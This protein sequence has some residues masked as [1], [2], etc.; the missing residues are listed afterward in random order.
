MYEYELEA[1]LEAELENELEWEGEYEGEWESELEAELEAEYEGEEFLSRLVGLARRGAQSP[2]LRRAGAVAARAARTLRPLGSRLRPA[3]RQTGLD[4]ARAGLGRLGSIGG[5]IGGAPGTPGSQFGSRVGGALGGLL[6]SFLP[7]SEF[8]GEWEFEGE[9]NPLRRVYPDALMEH[10]AH[11]ATETESEEEA[12]AFIGALVPLAARLIPRV[13]PAVMRAAPQLI[14]G[15]A[16]VT[17]VLRSSPATRQLV[18]TVPNIVRRTAAS[19]AQQA[20]QGR[21]VTPARAV[22]T[23]ARQTARVISSPQRSAQAIQRSRALDRQHHRTVGPAASAV[24]PS[25]AAMARR[26]RNYRCV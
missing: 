4:L 22:Q 3:L 2:L 5:A 10:L 12:E 26:R 25:A 16:N 9:V 19:M 14:R 23:L 6:G 18:R 20:S 7:D 8:E 24:T 13:A 21:P 11:A 15:V 1:E 17:R